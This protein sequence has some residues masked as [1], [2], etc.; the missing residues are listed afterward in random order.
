MKRVHS[1]LLGLILYF[2]LATPEL[3]T[4]LIKIPTRSRPEQFFRILDLYY[5]K[6]SNEVPYL[7]LI[8]CDNN[9]LTMNNSTIIERFKQYPHLIVTFND[10]HSK[11]EAYNR[12][13]DR[14]DFG[15]AVITSDDMTPVMQNYDKIIVD[16]ML[17]HFPD[18]DGVLNFND[19]HITSQ[20]NTMPI[21]GKKYYDRFGYAYHPSYTSLWCDTEFTF[22][23]RMLRKEKTCTTV[24]I[25][26]DHPYFGQATM[27]DL[28]VQNNQYYRVDEKVF[29]KRIKNFF[30]VKEKDVLNSCLKLW[31]ILICSLP[32][33]K[34]WQDKTVAQLNEQINRLG[35][36]N[37]IEIVVDSSTQELSHKRNELSRESLGKYHNFI[38]P[39]M[40]ISDDYIASIYLSLQYNPDVTIPTPFASS[41][42]VPLHACPIKRNIGLL[43]T[44]L[45]K[46][47]Q[48]EKHWAKNLEKSAVIKT[49]GHTEAEGFNINKRLSHGR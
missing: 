30:D 24:L 16:M 14:I 28:Y 34:K 49:V 12:D 32:E 31:S 23:S 44:F 1:F 19:G 47:N 10:N 43:F 3:P 17:A 27:D 36:G 13:L 40:Y 4:L 38:D 21:F 5:E 42:Q 22:V 11:V 18:L 6:L 35:I 46:Y 25:Q 39:G 2:Q 9:D 33:H 26:H 45:E 29:F 8:S 37:V 48:A 20:C 7:F 15:I 41:T